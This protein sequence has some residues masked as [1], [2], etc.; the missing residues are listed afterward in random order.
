MLLKWNNYYSRTDKN[1]KFDLILNFLLFISSPLSSV[2]I[3]HFLLWWTLSKCKYEK[4]RNFWIIK[5]IDQTLLKVVVLSFLIMQSVVE[6]DKVVVVINVVVWKS[7]KNID[8]VLRRRFRLHLA[9]GRRT[10]PPPPT[11]LRQMRQMW[12]ISCWR[13]FFSSLYIFIREPVSQTR[14]WL[15]FKSKELIEKNCSL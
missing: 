5:V 12:Q 3:R 7:V 14:S 9:R 13:R 1:L 2:S 11:F 4:F 10:P 8:D 6:D 15:L